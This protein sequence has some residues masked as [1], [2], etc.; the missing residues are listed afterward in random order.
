MPGQ[1]VSSGNSQTGGLTQLVH[2]VCSSLDNKRNK[3]KIGKGPV[4]DI[5]G[6]LTD[7]GD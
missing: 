4:T 5:A 3:R 7:E 6:L 1:S 2:S